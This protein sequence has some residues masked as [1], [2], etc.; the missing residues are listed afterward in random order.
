M[1]ATSSTTMVYENVAGPPGGSTIISDGSR[2]TVAQPAKESDLAQKLIDQFVQK[3]N[4]RMEKEKEK[5][6]EEI[7]VQDPVLEK[8]KRTRASSAEDKG[9]KITGW[10]PQ[11]EPDLRKGRKDIESPGKLS[12]EDLPKERGGIH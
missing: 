4:L 12:D 5:E 1:S 7:K 2:T 11:G 10:T 6:G 3:L 9:V 8:F